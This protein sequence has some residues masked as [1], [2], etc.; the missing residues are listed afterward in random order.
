MDSGC[1]G[2]VSMHCRE[3]EG[4]MVLEVMACR[5]GSLVCLGLVCNRTMQGPHQS[6]NQSHSALTTH[7]ANEHIHITCHSSVL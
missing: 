4:C 2:T 1:S 3:S 5:H 6:C 7:T